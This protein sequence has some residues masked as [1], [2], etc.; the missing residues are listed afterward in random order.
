MS[1]IVLVL[2]VVALFIAIATSPSYFLIQRN[3]VTFKMKYQSGHSPLI[4]REKDLGEVFG[5]V[6]LVGGITALVFLYAKKK[7]RR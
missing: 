6:L 7:E 5:R 2:G 3:G 1:K 4:Q